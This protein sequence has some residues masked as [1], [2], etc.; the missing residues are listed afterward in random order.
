MSGEE[1]RNDGLL[2]ESGNERRRSQLAPPDLY[3]TAL[4]LDSTA[5]RHRGACRDYL[6][7]ARWSA[8]F[9]GS[10]FQWPA[11]GGGARTPVGG[12]VGALVGMGIPEY[13]AKRY[14]GRM[15]DRPCS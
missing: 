1:K 2:G 7:Q 6:V 11:W 4:F 15:L 12:L 3:V 8:G 13:E 9:R 5:V 10:A 14:E